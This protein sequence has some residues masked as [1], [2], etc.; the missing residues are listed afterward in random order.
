MKENFLLKI[1]LIGSLVG[2][3]ILFFISEQIKVDDTSI[4]RLDELDVDSAVKV[5]GI[6]TRISESD[7]IAVLQ[8]TQPKSASVIVFKEGNLTGFRQGDLVSVDGR[9]QEYQGSFQIIANE[10]KVIGE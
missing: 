7:K 4:D 9:M 3:I 8:L 6:I 10:I 2:V 1:S 5:K